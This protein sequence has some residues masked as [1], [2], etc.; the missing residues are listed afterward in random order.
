MNRSFSLLGD[1]F[2]IRLEGWLPF[3]TFRRA[4]FGHVLRGREAVL[5]IERGASL[6]WFDTN[7]APAVA[8]FAG[9]YEAKPRLRIPAAVP[10]QVARR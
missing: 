2:L 5:T 9:L 7:G 3:E 6:V 4:G 10:Q 1:E 8:Y